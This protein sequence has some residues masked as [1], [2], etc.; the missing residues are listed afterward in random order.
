MVDR[1]I[2]ICCYRTSYSIGM[3]STTEKLKRGN[4]KMGALYSRGM[5]LERAMVLDKVLKVSRTRYRL[6]TTR[7][8][9]FM[10]TYG[11]LQFTP[12]RVENG[13]WAASTS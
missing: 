5:I 4:F 8:R 3:A 9:R 13:G 7:P 6:S 11:Y 10:A 12:P 2:H 1:G